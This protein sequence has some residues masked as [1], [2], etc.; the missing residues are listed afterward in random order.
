MSTTI[1][2][3]ATSCDFERASQQNHFLQTVCSLG[4][5]C[6]RLHSWTSA[7]RVSG[8]GLARREVGTDTASIKGLYYYSTYYCSSR[9]GEHT[10]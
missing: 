5:R 6:Q 2:T 9:A 10:M 8:P 3:A 7:G 1:P 4:T